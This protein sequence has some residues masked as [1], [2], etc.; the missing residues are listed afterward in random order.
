MYMCATMP[1]YSVRYIYY[2]TFFYWAL[3]LHGPQHFHHLDFAGNGLE[4]DCIITPGLWC[5]DAFLGLKN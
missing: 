3:N 4:R 2:H 5:N 1:A